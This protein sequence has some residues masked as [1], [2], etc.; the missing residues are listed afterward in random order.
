MRTAFFVL[1]VFLLSESYDYLV[2]VLEHICRDMVRR[3]L[4][5]V[6]DDLL[7]SAFSVIGIVEGHIELLA[8]ECLG[9]GVAAPFGGN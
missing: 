2:F 1:F 5:A 7:Y 3:K 9:N 4:L 8:S 6:E